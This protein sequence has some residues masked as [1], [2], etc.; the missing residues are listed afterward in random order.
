[1][2]G[3]PLGVTVSTRV[4]LSEP[5]ALV[6]VSVTLV[7]PSVVGVPLIVLPLK[8]SPAGSGVAENEKGAVPVA[9]IV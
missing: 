6:A 4:L 3:D 7:A 2:D 8:L 5:D 1:M 9:V